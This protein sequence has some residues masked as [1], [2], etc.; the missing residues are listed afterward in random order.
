MITHYR[1]NVTIQPD[2]KAE[3]E[4]SELCDVIAECSTFERQINDRN[5]YIMMYEYFKTN[6]H[7]PI[8]YFPLLSNDIFDAILCVV[9]DLKDLTSL[10]YRQLE[11]DVSI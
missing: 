9:E 6:K 4:I 10:D 7:F 1:N 8:K 3:L 5:F 11:N 2:S